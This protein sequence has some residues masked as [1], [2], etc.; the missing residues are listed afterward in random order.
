MVRLFWVR[1]E[2]DARLVSSLS[3][4]DARH[5][6][7]ELRRAHGPRDVLARLSGNLFGVVKV[8]VSD[9]PSALESSFGGQV[10]GNRDVLLVVDESCVRIDSSSLTAFNDHVA[11]VWIDLQLEVRRRNV[12]QRAITSEQEILQ[13]VAFT[14]IYESLPVV[15]PWL[16]RRG[17]LFESGYGTICCVNRADRLAQVRLHPDVLAIFLGRDVGG[18]GAVIGKLVEHIRV[19]LD[20]ALEYID[21]GVAE[22]T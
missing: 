20:A 1:T 17:S 8:G 4:D 5:F 19:V 10:R 7:G 21:L 11:D 22:L 6:A 18:R 2:S 13:L 16:R 12:E 14:A 9:D 3:S 15:A